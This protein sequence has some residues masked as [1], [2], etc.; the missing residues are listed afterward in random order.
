M[1]N[2][3]E[4]IQGIT[5]LT[6]TVLALLLIPTAA[7]AEF[8]AAGPFSGMVCNK[9][10]MACSIQRVDAVEGE[11]G[12]MF[13]LARSYES[14]SE[15]NSAQRL[16]TVNLSS[17]FLGKLF[18]ADFFQRQQDRSYKK[19]NLKYLQFSCVER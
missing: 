18:G 4:N 3:W 16:C 8:V 2:L 19:L 17:G 7:S 15:Y 9:L 1:K 11:G 10:G 13:N 6:A 14:V 5:V 12:Q